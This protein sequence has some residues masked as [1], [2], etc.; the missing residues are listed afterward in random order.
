MQSSMATRLIVS[1]TAVI[2]AVL[3]SWLLF[4]SVS[5]NQAAIKLV[6]LQQRNDARRSMLGAIQERIGAR[7]ARI[8]AASRLANSVGPAV[9]ADLVALSHDKKNTAISD[10]LQRHGLR[11]PDNPKSTPTP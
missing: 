9:L 1:H 3:A 4:E 10:L 6:E 2:A 5:N 8:D 7:R 11:A